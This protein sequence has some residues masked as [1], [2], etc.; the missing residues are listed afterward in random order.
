MLINNRYKYNSLNV[1][2]FGGDGILGVLS[3]LDV[4][5]NFG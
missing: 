4:S 2:G 1:M 5:G 3:Y